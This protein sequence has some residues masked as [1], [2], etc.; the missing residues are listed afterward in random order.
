MIQH[1][2]HRRCEQVTD[3]V[4]AVV[5]MLQEM[6]AGW[7]WSRIQD[8]RHRALVNED[9]DLRLVTRSQLP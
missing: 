2:A 4:E 3:M 7:I 6:G 8:G 5:L 9:P 1:P